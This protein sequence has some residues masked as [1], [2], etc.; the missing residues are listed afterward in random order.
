MSDCK[1]DVRIEFPVFK[2]VGI[3]FLIT[4][5]AQKMKICVYLIFRWRPSWIAYCHLMHLVQDVYLIEKCDLGSLVPETI[6]T[7]RGPLIKHSR[8]AANRWSYFRIF[9]T[10]SWIKGSRRCRIVNLTSELNFPPSN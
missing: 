7:F 4:I 2:L 5:I 3:D 6:I 10:P 8:T 1:S 9:C